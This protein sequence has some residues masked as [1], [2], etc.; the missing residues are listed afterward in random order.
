MCVCETEV[1]VVVVVVCVWGGGRGDSLQ[2]HCCQGF[3]ARR[4]GFFQKHCRAMGGWRCFVWEGGTAI[5][6]HTASSFFFH[7]VEWGSFFPP[8]GVSRM[9]A[10]ASLEPSPANLH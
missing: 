6:F 4:G 8:D 3:R 5:F 9:I 7:G 10:L 2:Q 1:V